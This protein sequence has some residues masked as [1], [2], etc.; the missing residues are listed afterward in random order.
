ML[1]LK[2]GNEITALEILAKFL[3]SNNAKKKKPT[4]V[5]LKS[6]KVYSMIQFYSLMTSQVG[7]FKN[8]SAFSSPRRFS[9]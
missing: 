3:R 5:S 8:A 4:L 6:T 1:G 2:F 7:V 9:H